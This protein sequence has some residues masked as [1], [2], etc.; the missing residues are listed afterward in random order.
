[1]ASFY[2]K[3]PGV[4]LAASRPRFRR[5]SKGVRTHSTKK[6]F[7]SKEYIKKLAI[8]EMEGKDKLEGALE[9]H[10][11]AMFPCPKHKYRKREPAKAV[12]KDNGPDVDNIAKHYMDALIASGIVA[13]DDR[14]VVSLIANKVQLAQGD[15][16]YTTVRVTEIYSDD[17]TLRD[18]LESI[19]EKL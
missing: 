16:P 7:E 5:T 18:F 6:T 19:L 9:V 13:D 3:I 8:K 12:L 4:P 17:N 14:Q 2:L 1:M 15:E 10:V 11:N